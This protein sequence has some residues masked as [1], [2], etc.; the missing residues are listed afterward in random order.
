MDFPMDG[1]GGYLSGSDGSLTPTADSS[2]SASLPSQDLQLNFTSFLAPLAAS[3]G[4]R[5]H[6][7]TEGPSQILDH[8]DERLT[9]LNRYID[10]TLGMRLA[11]NLELPDAQSVPA[12]LTAPPLQQHHANLPPPPPVDDYHMSDGHL[13]TGNSSVANATPRPSVVGLPP[14]L[15]YQHYEHQSGSQPSNDFDI[16]RTG[17][18]PLANEASS[19]MNQDPPANQPGSAGPDMTYLFR[20]DILT[21]REQISRLSGL[22]PT[23]Q[24]IAGTVADD[25]SSIRRNL[26]ELAAGL[27]ET[28][29]LIQH[30]P[31]RQGSTGQVPPASGGQSQTPSLQNPEPVPRSADRNALALYYRRVGAAQASPE[32]ERFVGMLRCYGVD[33]MSTDE[34][35]HGHNGTGYPQ[36]RVRHIRWRHPAATQCFRVLDALHRNKRFR[37]IR[38]MGPGALAHQRLS[39]N[40]VS[41]RPPVPKLPAGLYN[42]DWLGSLPRWS[43]GD[44]APVQAGASVDFSHH[45]SI[46]DVALQNHGHLDVAHPYA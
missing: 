6:P 42:P 38:R 33:G 27:A 22:I 2:H 29:R 45:P 40:V 32:T 41:N 17:G 25:I 15:S 37:P 23:E 36:Y 39:S 35:D 13:S 21:I 46:I 26:S 4:N 31:A 30:D 9:L 20:E 10:T 43:L 11:Q 24:Q 1:D 14:D 16:P 28:H 12:D 34:S 19:A 5:V 7:S 8:E 18:A 44:L 3:S